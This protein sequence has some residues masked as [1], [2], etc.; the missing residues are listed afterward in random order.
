MEIQKVFFLNKNM[1][2][3]FSFLQEEEEEELPAE[4]EI[5]EVSEE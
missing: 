1:E 5:E 3:D 4:E 2:E